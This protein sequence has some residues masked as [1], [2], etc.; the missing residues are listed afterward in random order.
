[1][2]LLRQSSEIAGETDQE[3]GDSFL[4]SSQV[5]CQ[6]FIKSKPCCNSLALE[7]ITLKHGL[8]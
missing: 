2:V 4:P 3:A 5:A 6:V 1:M 8:D 7:L